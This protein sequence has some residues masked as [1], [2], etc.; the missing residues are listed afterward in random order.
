MPPAKLPMGKLSINIPG[1]LQKALKLKA[2]QENTSV[3]AMLLD[4][5]RQMVTVTKPMLVK[6]AEKPLNLLTERELLHTVLDKV[7]NEYEHQVRA[8]AFDAE[9]N[10]A[11]AIAENLGDAERASQVQ[12]RAKPAETGN[13]VEPTGRRAG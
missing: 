10:R 12:E 7:L 8:D 6:K 4:A 13:D 9:D 1:D 2:V 11:I 5:A 3:T